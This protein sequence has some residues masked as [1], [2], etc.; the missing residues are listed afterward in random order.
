MNLCAS[1]SDKIIEYLVQ[2][3]F[4]RERGRNVASDYLITLQ[5]IVFAKQCIVRRNQENVVYQV[6]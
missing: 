1:V 5:A 6:S 2:K 4:T 3:V